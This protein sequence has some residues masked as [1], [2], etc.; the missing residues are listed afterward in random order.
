[1]IDK[2]ETLVPES[3]YHIYNR[4]NGFDRLFL[5]DKNYLYFLEKYKQ[6]ISPMADTFCYCLMPN[7]FH[8]LLRIKPENELRN[9]FDTKT[10]LSA[11]L[12][13][14]RTLEG[15]AQQKALS[16]L[17][18]QQF[19]HLMNGYTQGLN[20]I[21]NRKGSLFMHPYKR[22][23]VSDTSYLTNLVK[24]IYLNPVEVGMVLNPEDW[25]HSSY[26]AL[27]KQENKLINANEVISWF[28]SLE[29]FKSFHAIP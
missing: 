2:L 21:L 7:H 14:Y 20:K 27:L 16:L 17:I 19:S 15:S 3:T 11:T 8:F 6:F 13:G 22:K 28:D 18:S 26:S 4:A 29:N 10:T 12:R 9:F 5:T 23:K 25:A 1:M 24:Y